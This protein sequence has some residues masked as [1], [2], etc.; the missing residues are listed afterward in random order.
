MILAEIVGHSRAKK[1]L[2]NALL[3]NRVAHAYLFCGPSGIGKTALTKAFAKALLC[4]NKSHNDACGR[5]PTCL[6]V[7]AGRFPDLSEV[8]PAGNNIKIEQI[9]EIQKKAQF[10]PFEAARKVYIINRADLLTREAANCLLKILEDPP[11]DTFFLLTTINAYNLPSTVVSR[12]QQVPLSRV[13]VKEIEQLLV[14]GGLDLPT[15]SLQ[16]SLAEGLPGRAFASGEFNKRLEARELVFQLEAKL[17]LGDINELFK[18]AEEFEKKR[19]ELPGFLEQLLLWYRDHLVWSSTFKEELIVNAD[20]V[21]KLKSF[22]RGQ[23]YYLRS[24]EDI[25]EAR[26]QIDQNVNIRLVMEVLFMRLAKVQ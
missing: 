5:C 1:V 9:R 2:H 26:K 10:K 17:E 11:P 8:S 6:R 15:A 21:N 12:C 24:V 16:A 3:E 20:M 22:G 14:K 18:A 23:E 19:E 25:M 13:P 7:E 4:P